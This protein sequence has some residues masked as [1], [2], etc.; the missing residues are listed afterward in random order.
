MGFYAEQMQKALACRAGDWICVHHAPRT[1]M[2]FT[3]LASMAS[4]YG[5]SSWLLSA[6]IQSMAVRFAI[7]FVLAYLV[8]L[9]VLGCWYLHVPRVGKRELLEQAAAAPRTQDPTDVDREE[10]AW[11]R[12]FNDGLEQAMQRNPQQGAAALAGLCIFAAIIGALI[13][14]FHWIRYAPWYLGQLLVLGGKVEHRAIPRAS[15]NAWIAVLLSQT[16]WVAII[17]FVHYVAIG[18]GLQLSFPQA[19]TVADVLRLMR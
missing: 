14:A 9:A 8:F 1:I 15:P 11:E 6:G 13:V 16:K 4:A 17:L 10:S 3:F 7:C 2:L 5:G 12:S 19:H 18:V